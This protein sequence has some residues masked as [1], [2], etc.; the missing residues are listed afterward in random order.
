M[1]PLVLQAAVHI[2]HPDGID[3]FDNHLGTLSHFS[4]NKAGGTRAE[5]WFTGITIAHWR[6]QNERESDLSRAEANLETKEREKREED[7]EKEK[8]RKK[9]Q[10]E[11]EKKNEEDDD[12]DSDSDDDDV[13]GL[14]PDPSPVPFPPAAVADWR[15]KGNKNAEQDSL[16]TISEQS[17]SLVVTGDGMGRNWTCSL[18]CDLMDEK[19]V[20]KFAI[21][22]KD[23]LQLFIHQQYTGRALVFTYLL[24][25]I[26]KMLAMEC[27]RF[28]GQIDQ[29]MGTQVWFSINDEMYM[30]R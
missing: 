20:A 17:I 5:M 29:I 19:M 27:E 9:K 24:G 14:G 13:R 23:I 18:I 22:I 4:D 8:K 28:V 21:E 10:E 16:S 12:W 3:T 26:C 15:T 25:Q 11:A 7:R 30:T 2:W 1:S 6:P